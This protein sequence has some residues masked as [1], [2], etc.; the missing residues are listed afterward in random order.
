V[1]NEVNLT[2]AQK[3]QQTQ[4]TTRQATQTQK[5]S[6]KF[7][8]QVG[9]MPLAS[10]SGPPSKPIKATDVAAFNSITRDD[11]VN[12]YVSQQQSAGNTSTQ[13]QI[14]QE[15]SDRYDLYYQ[16]VNGRPPAPPSSATTP[17]QQ[18]TWLA[19][20]QNNVQAAQNAA[21]RSNRSPLMRK[22]AQ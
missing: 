13:A 1:M 12:A 19:N 2:P 20:F 17:Q 6:Q 7:A 9:S 22:M 14:S 4:Q 21:D 16:Q 10:L 3:K 5:N 11:F 18:A 15:A 8:Q